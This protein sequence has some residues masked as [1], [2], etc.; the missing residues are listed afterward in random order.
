MGTKQGLQRV[1][2]R[3]L[4][5]GDAELLGVHAA[6]RGSGTADQDDPEERSDHFV[7]RASASE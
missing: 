7:F 2:R 1:L 3:T 4:D 6:G 5:R